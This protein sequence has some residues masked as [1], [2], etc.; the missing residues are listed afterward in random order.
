MEETKTVLLFDIDGTLTAPRELI[1]DTMSQALSDLNIPFHVAAG[2]NMDLVEPQLLKPLYEHGFRKDFHAF[3][4]NGSAHFGCAFSKAYELKP[5]GAFDFE[6]HLGS[7]DFEFLMAE[8]GN[9]MKLPEFALPALV[10]VM[11]DQVK[12]RGSMVNFSPSGRPNAGVLNDAA[13]KNRKAFVTF[14]KANSYRNKLVDFLES[15]LGRLM[16][17]KHL[18]IMLGGETSFDIVIHGQDKTAPVRWLLEKGVE[19]I[20]FIGDALFPGGNDSV[21]QDFVDSW[22]KDKKCPVVTISVESWQETLSVLRSRDWIK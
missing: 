22:N 21:V 15:R 13:L 14:D 2:S 12:H 5:L 20:V 17:E 19:E 7:A 1:C 11:G 18:K 10:N 6:A 8:L 3:V 4:N 16:N 9:A